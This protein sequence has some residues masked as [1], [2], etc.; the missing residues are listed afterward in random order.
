MSIN[1]R[2]AL[3]ST[4]ALLLTG[5]GSTR[6]SLAA[7]SP[8]VASLDK[9]QLIYLT[10]LLGDGRESAC[11]GEVWFVNHNKE[12]FVVTAS[13]AWRAEALRRGHKRAAIWIG[14]FG[15]WKKAEDSY[16]SAH[17]LV[18]EGHLETEA[19]VHADVLSTYSKKYAEEWGSWGPRFQSGLADGS[20]V[21][22]RYKISA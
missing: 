17:H 20:R 4:T 2:Q 8:A 12:I 13:D 21:M 1:R 18:I 16:R 3:A 11:H 9:S 10:P 6:I 7:E 15:N 14:E 5:L 22:L 19:S